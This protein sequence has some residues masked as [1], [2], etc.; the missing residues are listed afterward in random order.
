[1]A[2]EVV[3]VEAAVKAEVA[4]V[5][6]W[7]LSHNRIHWMLFGTGMGAGFSLY[8]LFTALLSH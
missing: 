2:D 7:V 6:G 5:E 1:M 8:A 4:K 3:K